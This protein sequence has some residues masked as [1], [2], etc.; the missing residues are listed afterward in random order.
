VTV[1]PDVSEQLA[2][3]ARILR[4][5]VAPS[6]SGA[7]PADILA[8]VI[9]TLDA[10]ATGW[11]DVPAFLAWDAAATLALLD[12]VGD[13]LAEEHGAARLALAAERPGPDVRAV[14]AHHTRVRALLADVV[15]AGPPPALVAPLAAHARERAARYPLDAA[16]RMPGE[17]TP[18]QRAP[19]RRTA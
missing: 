3:A 11:A 8:G 7:Y 1:R 13:D 6:V 18:G 2:G 4:D 9:A 16:Q 12:A 17:S 10:V 5:V 19:G 14:A 15:T